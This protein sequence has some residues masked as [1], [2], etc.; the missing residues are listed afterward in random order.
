M[1]IHNDASFAYLRIAALRPVQADANA[2]QA[3]RETA[4]SDG[5]IAA[6]TEVKI[7]RKA[8]ADSAM[9]VAAQKVV[10]NGTIKQAEG[11]AAGTTVDIRV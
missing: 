1:D 10:W 7:Q 4:G 9:F 11:A 8:A 5:S 3:Q 2:R 6:D